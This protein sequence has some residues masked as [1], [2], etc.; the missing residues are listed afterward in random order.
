MSQMCIYE[1][2]QWYCESMLTNIYT[3]IIN[4]KL[5]TRDKIGEFALYIYSLENVVFKEWNFGPD[6]KDTIFFLFL[7]GW[8]LVWG[9]GITF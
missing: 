7:E 6:K 2:Y 4:E 3:F 1:K 5:H 8:K 9:F